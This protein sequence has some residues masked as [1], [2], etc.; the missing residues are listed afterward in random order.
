M[1]SSVASKSLSL[2]RF[3]STV[4]D[5]GAAGTA[6]AG[7]EVVTHTLA[8]GLDIVV[9]PDRRVPVVTHMVW[10]RNGSGDDPARK[11]GIA[12]FLEHLM[13]KGTKTHPTGEF[14]HLVASLGGQ[15]NAFTSYDYT[16]YYQRIAKEH[17]GTM[18]HY[19]ADRMTGLVLSDDV[20]DPERLVVLEERRLRTD[21]DPAAQ[22]HEAVAA[23][24]YTH[25]P[26][27][28][29]II[30]W[31]HEIETL[32][33]HDAVA[34]YE[35]FY[36]PE[37]AILVVA[38]DVEAD[39]V[40]RLAE[41]T[42]GL[43]APRGARPVRERAVEP[44]AVAEKRVSVS[45]ARVEQPY[46]Q[47]S[48]VVPSARTQTGSEAYALELLS[49]ILGG[50][51]TSLLYRHLVLDQRVAVGAGSGYHASM[52]NDSRFD[53]YAV[54]APGITLDAL[55]EAVSGVIRQLIDTGVSQAELERARTR[56][57]AE[58]IYAQD[59]QVHMAHI[60][61]SALAI[62]ETV[63]DVQQWTD[64]IEAVDAAAVQEAARR[65]LTRPHTSGYLLPA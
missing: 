13:F 9:I 39:D 44:A 35:R 42:Y 16:A 61:G 46:L 50:G 63:A 36:T 55:D 29:P 64:R 57:I 41:S 28:T 31:N 10:Y 14:S 2:K 23:T 38:G 54:P 43:I 17:L 26:Y 8:N 15:E 3:A 1:T 53:V 32:D 47:R 5:T 21:S 22:L 58:M 7:A 49:E 40:I 59:S 18:M 56:F 48:W 52:L 11:S 12:H 65:F 30:G 19:E 33:R 37:N 34:Y 25:N 20:V 60:Y 51:Q 6:G 62:G 4:A 45:D 24:L 27:G